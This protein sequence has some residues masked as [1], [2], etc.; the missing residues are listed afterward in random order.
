MKLKQFQAR[1]A[2][3]LKVELMMADGSTAITAI[4]AITDITV[5]TVITASTAHPLFLLL[6]LTHLGKG[7]DLT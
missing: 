3:G 2:S 7:T 1:A 4:T 6:Y 5:I